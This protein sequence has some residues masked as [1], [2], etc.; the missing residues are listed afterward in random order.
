MKNT[1]L[2]FLLVVTSVT[3]I[4]SLKSEVRP[5]KIAPCLDDSKY[6]MEKF[7]TKE[8]HVVECNC[9]CPQTKIVQPRNQCLDCMH[10]HANPAWEIIKARPTQAK[11]TYLAPKLVL[12]P[13]KPERN[14]ENIL[15]K[16]ATQIQLHGS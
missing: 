12:D 5:H 16:L 14:I 13:S 15:H 3:I 4:T 1:W 10:Y 6:L 9:P 8:L 2:F 11:E 7:D